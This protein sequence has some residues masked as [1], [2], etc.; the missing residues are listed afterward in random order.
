MFN[1]HFV[2]KNALKSKAWAALRAENR[3]MVAPMWATPQGDRRGR[4]GRA[5]G[6]TLDGG[7]ARLHFQRDAGVVQR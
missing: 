2:S 4:A 5:I 3:C 1:E 7:A 6:V